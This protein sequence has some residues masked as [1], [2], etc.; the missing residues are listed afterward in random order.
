MK[1]ISVAIPVRIVDIEQH[2]ALLRCLTSVF[3]QSMR[4]R[5][6]IISVD[7]SACSLE[8]SLNY[9]FAEENYKIVVNPNGPGIAINS[10]NALNFCKGDL[11]HILH[12]DDEIISRSCYESVLEKYQAEEFNWLMLEGVTKSGKRI[13]PSFDSHT[14][15]GINKMGGPSGLIAPIENY[16]EF[17]SAYSMMT[18]VVNFELYFRKYGP[19]T[20]LSTPWILYGDL[21]SSASKTI[22]RKL[23]IKELQRLS[24][25]LEISNEEICSFIKNRE[26]DPSHQKLV[27]DAFGSTLNRIDQFIFLLS[28]VG[29]KTLKKLLSQIWNQSPIL[30]R[31]FS[32]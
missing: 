19:P 22:P 15:F 23:I 26:L 11:V 25:Q 21:S 3:S 12:Q 16:L 10:N 13:E 29:R 24:N 6:V 14:K 2:Q 18:D 32:K 8:K 17:D 28:Y 7:G 1:S 4:P 31:K 20:I 30:P 5:E 9:E 27:F